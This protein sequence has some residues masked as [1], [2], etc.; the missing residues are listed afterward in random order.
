MVVDPDPRPSASTRAAS[1]ITSNSA[2]LNGTVN[3]HNKATTYRFEYGTTTNYGSN[4]A[5]TSAG[6]G[7]SEVAATTSV[8]GLAAATTYHYRLV[9]TNAS[10]TNS[11]A[12]RTL[13]T[14]SVF[15]PSTPTAPPSTPTA[16]PS[17]PTAPLSPGLDTS[18]PVLK[19]SRRRVRLG[20]RRRLRVRVTCGAGEPEHCK[21][22]LRLYTGPRRPRVASARFDI[23]PGHT[24]RVRLRLSRRGARL[25]KRKG[26]LRILAIGRARDSAGILGEKQARFTLLP[27]HRSRDRHG[28]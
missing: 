4:T 19:V 27:L 5:N 13:R 9:A 8:S 6:S 22:V 15:P 3:P 24:A 11:G 18:A 10:G 20:A 21:G 1:A 17:T 25:L 7:N 16:P 14:A 26:R 28:R 23:P 2:T 12:D